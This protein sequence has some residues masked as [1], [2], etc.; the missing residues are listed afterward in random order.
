[1]QGRYLAYAQYL[2]QKGL[3]GLTDYIMKHIHEEMQAWPLEKKYK[4]EDICVLLQNVRLRVEVQNTQ[5]GEVQLKNTEIPAQQEE[6]PPFL[7]HRFLLPSETAEVLDDK[8]LITLLN[9]T[10][11]VLERYKNS[12]LTPNH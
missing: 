6:E 1:M 11:D 3:K 7:W 5:S 9:E 10:R 2:T 8:Q 4:F 12:T